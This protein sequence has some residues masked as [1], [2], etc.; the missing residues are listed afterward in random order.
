MLGDDVTKGATR[1]KALEAHLIELSDDD[2]GAEEGGEAELAIVEAA[3][4]A[5]R[6][7]RKEPALPS[8][9][10]LVEAR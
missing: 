7:R 9:R 6:E 2:G 10:G 3:E 5:V 8:A 4:E 1:G